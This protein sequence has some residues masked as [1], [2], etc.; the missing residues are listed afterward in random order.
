MPKLT[1]Y[2]KIMYAL[3]DEMAKRLGLEEDWI[4]TAHWLDRRALEDGIDLGV[5][6]D[7]PRN[8]SHDLIES[9]RFHVDFEQRWPNG[10]QDLEGTGENA[11]DLFW[12]I[13]PSFSRGD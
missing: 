13:M 8:W 2:E 4:A 6:Y 10:V 9:L 7:N 1:H 11:E 3:A 12:H 5:R